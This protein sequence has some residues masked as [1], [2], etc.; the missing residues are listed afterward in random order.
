MG[1]T[2]GAGGK[3]KKGGER[4]KNKIC[5]KKRH[6]ISPSGGGKMIFLKV[7]VRKY[8]WLAFN[9]SHKTLQTFI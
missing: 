9:I 4:R 2:N 8:Y 5:G 3:M 7:K 6:K 1:V